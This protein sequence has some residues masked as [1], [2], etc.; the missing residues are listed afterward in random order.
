MATRRHGAEVTNGVRRL[1]V[2]NAPAAARAVAP[3]IRS[4]LRVQA[5]NATPRFPI[6][7]E[8]GVGREVSSE[9][10]DPE[11]P[12]AR[13]QH[14]EARATLRT[15]VPRT[16]R[17]S[18]VLDLLRCRAGPTT[19]EAK[20][21]LLPAVRLAMSRHM[22]Q[23]VA[24][25]GP[26]VGAAVESIAWQL[27]SGWLDRFR[28]VNRGTTHRTELRRPKT[29]EPL[30]KRELE[31]LRFLPTRMTL[32]EIGAELYVTENTVKTHVRAIYRKFGCSGRAEVASLMRPDAPN[33][34]DGSS[35]AQP[36][37]RMSG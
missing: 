19:E 17:Q 30:T 33:L 35:A 9:T 21:Y 14:S 11:C 8:P 1:R 3:H 7:E 4:C 24:S 32:R 15:A 22:V 12:L 37:M 16:D 6:A 26:E 10:G 20:Q 36:Y 23:T 28:A 31:V 18:V 13:G 2:L 5:V 27:T 29:V 34:R 25:K